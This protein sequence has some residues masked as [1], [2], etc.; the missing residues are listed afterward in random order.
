MKGEH[1]ATPGEISG[2]DA[3]I[4]GKA[5]ARKIIQ[6]EPGVPNYDAR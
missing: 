5:I 4:Q 6:S 1:P 2:D 3:I